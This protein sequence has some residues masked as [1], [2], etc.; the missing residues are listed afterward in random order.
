[1]SQD[2]VNLVKKYFNICPGYEVVLQTNQVDIC[3]GEILEITEEAWPFLVGGLVKLYF[4]EKRMNREDLDGISDDRRSRCASSLIED[5][6]T[7]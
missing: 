3:E 6:T 1:M 4:E 5:I 7:L 2:A